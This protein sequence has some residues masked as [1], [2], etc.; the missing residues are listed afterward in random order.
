MDHV[1]ER[2]AGVLASL[3]G[4]KEPAHFGEEGLDDEDLDEEEPGFVPAASCV[5][6]TES[7]DAGLLSPRALREML[8]MGPLKEFN[9]PEFFMALQVALLVYYPAIACLLLSMHSF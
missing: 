4:S 3:W 8:V 1:S 2:L 5:K 9:R 6:W 7:V